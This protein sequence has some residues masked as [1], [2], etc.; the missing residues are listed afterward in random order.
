[1]NTTAPIVTRELP[2]RER[3]EPIPIHRLRREAELLRHSDG[4]TALGIPRGSPQPMIVASAARMRQRYEP[5]LR[6]P[7]P[8]AREYG[9]EILRRVADAE[10]ALTNGG[11]STVDPEVA[12]HV[13][14][15]G[16]ALERG[17]FARADR[18]F[19][20]ARRL[21][22][23]DPGVLAHLAWARFKNPEH[24]R[25]AREDEAIEL[26]AMALQFDAESAITWRYKG[27]IARARGEHDAART[28]LQT[29]VRLSRR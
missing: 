17:D 18:H 4:W 23:N 21:A 29:A 15:G 25:P 5:L 19:S 9:S 6:D 26:I 16:V 7:N 11:G 28:A 8:D 2:G 14:A 24:K 20:T 1:M 10:G 3:T 13:A 27:E 12:D 22:P